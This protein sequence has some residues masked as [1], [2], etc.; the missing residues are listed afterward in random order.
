MATVSKIGGLKDQLKTLRR[1]V[2]RNLYAAVGSAK[3]DREV[4]DRF[5][6]L[7]YDSALMGLT[8][9]DTKWLGVPVLKCPLDLWLYQE[10]FFKVKPDWVIETG[11]AAGGSALYIASLFDLLNK[12]K[13]VSIDIESRPDKPVHPRITYLTGSSTSTEIVDKV[14]AMIGGAGTVL[15]ILDSDH[16]ENHV[17]EELKIYQQIVTPHSYLVVEDSNING[18]PVAPKNGPGP[19]E[20]I[21]KFLQGNQNFEVDKSKEKFLMSFNPKGYLRRLN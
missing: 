13:V 16:S 14:K 4:V 20:A 10:I 2:Y 3:N 18:H 12:G 8:W 7:Y 1:L 9:S 15:V 21:T 11:T 5:H 17:A 19:M 6:E